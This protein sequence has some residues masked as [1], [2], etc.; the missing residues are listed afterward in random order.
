MASALGDS[1][2]GS[3]TS[4]LGYPKRRGPRGLDDKTLA[5][6]G[7]IRLVNPRTGKTEMF[8]CICCSDS[9]SS[10]QDCYIPLKNISHHQ[11]TNKHI[12]N[13]EIWHRN[14]S[15]R[16]REQLAYDTA[17]PHETDAEDDDF[18]MD[19]DDPILP[20]IPDEDT[21]NSQL[22]EN[23][24]FED[25]IF[26]L[27]DETGL[28]KL[29]FSV[30]ESEGSEEMRQFEEDIRRLQLAKEETPNGFDGDVDGDE[31]DGEEF[32]D[33]I[34][35]ENTPLE[36]DVDNSWSPWPN[37]IYCLLDV[38]D[39]LGRM[40][41]STRQIRLILW[42][43]RKLNV[44]NVP[45]YYS[46]RKIQSM[47]RDTVN[48]FP[49]KNLV[50]QLGNHFTVTDP[51]NAIALQVAHPITSEFITRYPAWQPEEV[52]EVWHTRRWY[53]FGFEML[54]PLWISP[55]TGKQFFVRE[56]TRMKNGELV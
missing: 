36:S 41:F 55:E 20:H 51:R 27:P 10:D 52:S 28:E 29:L 23:N 50:S 47:V 53:E 12:N 19:F 30:L 9:V 43:L 11:K 31:G 46:F 40:R 38:M 16:E 37:K 5:Q 25:E 26:S 24:T 8:K 49:T 54:N 17:Y 39:S 3:P 6:R 7:F 15:Q 56:V 13:H 42:L 18:P 2:S 4:G 1:R 44:P 22:L 14:Q 45:S 33:S 35:P 48:H 21:F 32:D 34:A